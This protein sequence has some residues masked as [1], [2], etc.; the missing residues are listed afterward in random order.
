MS[1][2]CSINSCYSVKFDTENLN[3]CNNRLV[4]YRV[5]MHAGAVCEKYTKI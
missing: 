4:I 3:R 5:G 2:Y 1:T